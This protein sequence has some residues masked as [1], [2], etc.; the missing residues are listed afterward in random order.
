MG[1]GFYPITGCG[2]GH[3]AFYVTEYSTTSPAAPG[4]LIKVTLNADGSAGTRTIMGGGLLK[5]QNGFAA[6]PD[7]SVYVSNHST[8]PGVAQSL[9]SPVGQVVRVNY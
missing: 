5:F 7:G 8:S 9:G 2:F 3:G 4:D 1:F 6:G